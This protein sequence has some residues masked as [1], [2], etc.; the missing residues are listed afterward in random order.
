MP[1]ITISE[2]GKTPQPYRLKTDR[3]TTKIGRSSDSDVILSAGSASTN[4][5]V[6]KR[7]PGGFILE[8]KNSTNGIKLEDAR[9][10]I[11]DLEDGMNV[12]IGDDI[13]FDFELTDE[14]IEILEKE[15]FESH[16]KAMFPK[17]KKKKKQAEPIDLD[18][19]E[20][21]DDEEEEVVVAKPKKK[22]KKPVDLDDE[23]N[24]EDE[25]EDEDDA[26]KRKKLKAAPSSGSTNTPTSNS[27]HAVATPKTTSLG[28]TILFILLA[29]AFLLAGMAIR[30]WQDY[31]TFI[32]S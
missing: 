15:D 23:D 32:F 16:Q 13:N 14:E 20:D 9:Y 19:E 25:D 7:V 28:S 1:R 29:V 31:K 18:D 12:K 22:K 4:H 27:R 30:H 2:P 5:C 26:P 17:A 8:D 3:K 10:S 11:I 21:D 24:D 6:M